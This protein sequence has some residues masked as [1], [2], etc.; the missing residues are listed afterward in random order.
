[1]R[2]TV[3]LMVL[4]LTTLKLMT[5]SIGYLLGGTMTFAQGFLF[6]NVAMTMLEQE[7]GDK[8]WSQLLISLNLVFLP[9]LDGQ[10]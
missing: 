4:R 6:S 10:R 3:M 8:V 7:M 1:M 2:P 5:E 9:V